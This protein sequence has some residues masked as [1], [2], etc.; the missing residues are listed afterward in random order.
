MTISQVILGRVRTT[1]ASFSLSFPHPPL[2]SQGSQ[3]INATPLSDT[4][5]MPQL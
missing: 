5:I 2:Y 4:Q 3:S 1:L